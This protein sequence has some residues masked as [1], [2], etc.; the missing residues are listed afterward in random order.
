MAGVNKQIVKYY[1]KNCL[2][3]YTSSTR[4]FDGTFN[5]FFH[6]VEDCIVIK[7]EG[8]KTVE[9]I[10]ALGV[11]LRYLKSRSKSLRFTGKQIT[12]QEFHEILRERKFEVATAIDEIKE[13]EHKK[14]LRINFD[15][16]P[17]I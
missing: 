7:T 15:N 13:P 6:K 12:E 17:K 10:T 2:L 16:F 3:K 5:L 11:E 9:W 4:N 1:F 8:K 14:Q